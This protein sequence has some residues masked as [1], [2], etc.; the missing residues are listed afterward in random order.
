LAVREANPNIGIT[1]I[2]AIFKGMVKEQ[3]DSLILLIIKQKTQYTLSGE[4]PKK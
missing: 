3:T 4:S 2:S 1:D